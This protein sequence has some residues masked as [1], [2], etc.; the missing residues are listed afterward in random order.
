MERISNICCEA[1][2]NQSINYEKNPAYFCTI[3]EK[4]QYFMEFFSPRNDKSSWAFN[5]KQFFSCK[6]YTN[7]FLL[8][9]IV[10]AHHLVWPSAVFYHVTRVQFDHFW[11]G[12][13]INIFLY[14]NKKVIIIILRK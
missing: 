12:S 7:S 13:G 6:C 10:E 3:S 1:R 8:F 4:K 11:L 5:S 9:P 2:K 14:N